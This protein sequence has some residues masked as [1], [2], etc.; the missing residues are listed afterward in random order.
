MKLK[1][2]RPCNILRKFPYNAYELE[3]LADIGISPI[4][5]VIDVYLYKGDA[6]EVPKDDQEKTKMSKPQFP[7]VDPLEIGKVMDRKLAKRTRNKECFQY[8]VKW[9]GH[10]VEDAT[11]MNEEI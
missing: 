1:N 10:P 3:F 6:T 8:F 2:I 9:K 5:N 11:S 7:T 4:F